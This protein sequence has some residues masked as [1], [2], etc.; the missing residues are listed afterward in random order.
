MTKEKVVIYGLTTE[1]YFLACQMAIKGADVYVVD[2][3]SP[4]AISLKSEVAKNCPNLDSFKEDEPLLAMVPIDIAISKAEYLF[5]TPRIRKINQ[6]LKLEVSSKFKDAVKKVK[7]GSTVVY[8]LATGFQ[9]NNE[10][11]SL[12]KHVT[13]LVA[14][15]SVYYYYFPLNGLSE[16]PSVIGSLNK[17]KD[18]KLLALLSVGKEEKKFVNISSAEYIHAIH[19]VKRFSGICSI[20]EVCKFVKNNTESST[21]FDDFKNMYLDDMMNGLDDLR[22]LGSSQEGT[23]PLLYLING[24]IKGINA[25]AK[26]LIEIIRITLKNHD[27]KASKTKIILSW[28]LD[29]NQMRGEKVEMLNNIT[30]KLRDYIGDVETSEGLL[31][32]FHSDKTTVAI[33]CTESDYK[34]I[35][36]IKQN[37]DIFLIK[38][39]PMFEVNNKSKII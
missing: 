25:Y 31:D 7:K 34:N 26:R 8:C 4:T 39:N 3:S 32:F 24:S 2:E 16:T 20:L 13:G 28:T 17:I 23:S 5:F 19:T 1:G 18:K 6:D 35:K 12:L 14:G 38:A 10:N 37:Q 27:L 15:K 11:I 21:T 33:A 22:L 36:E 9:G 30:S 29:K